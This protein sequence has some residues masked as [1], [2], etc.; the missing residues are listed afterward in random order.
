MSD[1]FPPDY[2]SARDVPPS[3]KVVE[4]WGAPV[5]GALDQPP[6][7]RRIIS[8]MPSAIRNVIC[9]ELLTW[10]VLNG[11]FRQY[12]WNSY[13]ITAQ[14][15]I[16]GFRAMG[17]EMHAELT[18]QACALLGECFPDERLARMEIVGEAGGRGIDFNALDDAFYALEEHER[19][20]SEAVLDAY[21]TAALNGQWQ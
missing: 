7:Y 12:F 20:S 2:L 21:A 6:K 11:G 1:K 17:L 15:A 18:R 16:Q 4:L 9:V 19:E 13:G 8:A 3:E 10:Q 5:I 14:G